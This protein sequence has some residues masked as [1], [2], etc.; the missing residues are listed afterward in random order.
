VKLKQIADNKTTI[1]E[2]LGFNSCCCYDCSL[3]GSYF[4]QFCVKVVST[5]ISYKEMYKNCYG[6]KITPTD[7]IKYYKSFCKVSLLSIPKEKLETDKGMT[8][9]T[10]H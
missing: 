3:L 9:M 10:E 8:N 7:Y 6:H 1:T 4:T 2:V 5:I